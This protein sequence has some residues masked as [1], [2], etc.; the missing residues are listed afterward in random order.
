V[1]IEQPGL[2]AALILFA[3]LFGAIFGSFLN[4]CILRWGAEP[5]ESVLHP[6]S[7][8][9]QCEHQIRWY[10][11][12]PILSWLA[13][14]GRCSG[15]GTRISPMYPAV[16]LAT[17]LLWAGA[18]ALM[19]PTLGALELAVASTLLVG[20]AVSDARAYII[21][22]E[23]SLGG[24]VI[25]LAF[26]AYP[27]LTGLLP[28]IWGALFGAG[29]ILLVGELTELAL[30]QEAMGGGD[31]ALMGM[32]GAFFGWQIVLPVVAF[33]AV[34]S[35]LLYAVA[36]WLPRPGPA[37]SVEAESAGEEQGLRWSKVLTLLLAGFA[38]LGLL[39]WSVQAGIV[40]PLLLALFHAV[41]GAGAAYYLSFLVPERLLAGGWTG[42]IGLLGAALGMAVGGG[43]AP[44]R[45]IAAVLLAAVAIWG[46]R[47]VEVTASPDTAE[48]LSSGGYIPFGVGLALAAGLLA[49]TGGPERMR[50]VFAELGPALGIV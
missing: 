7:H 27:D 21:P 8:C 11:N 48:E 29:V 1:P 44:D 38:L 26:A 34:I 2:E 39:A 10:E 45:L 31:C 19:G 4:V 13:L 24:T 16:E 22:H 40:G 23:L 43:F 28:A 49:Y 42:V 30:G 37:A 15:C 33:G 32:V 50:Q 41:L 25:A 5:K 6:P 18:V 14:R 3:A 20:I 46:V 35:L 47:R 17:A 36:V 12:I 9:P